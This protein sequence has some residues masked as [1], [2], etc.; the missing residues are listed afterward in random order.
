[1]PSVPRTV[2]SSMTVRAM[3]RLEGGAPSRSVTVTTAAC[4]PRRS[5][6]RATSAESMRKAYPTEKGRPLGSEGPLSSVSW[7][8]ELVLFAERAGAEQRRVRVLREVQD[9]RDRHGP[10]QRMHVAGLAANELDERVA[11]EAGADAVGDRVRE[12]HD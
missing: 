9:K 5:A 4:C 6:S 2:P 11:H 10:E 7:A 12:R 8:V 3:R 1:Q